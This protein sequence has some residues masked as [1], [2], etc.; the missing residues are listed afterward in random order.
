MHRNF[1]AAVRALWVMAMIVLVMAS[2][3]PIKKQVYLQTE[4]SDTTKSE[5]ILDNTPSYTLQPGNNLYIKVFSVDDELYDFFNLGFG[6][7]GNI[8]YD[9]AVYLNSYSV[10]D[11]GKVELPFIGEIFV[12]DLTLEQ[13]KNKIQQ[14]IDKYL[15]NTMII[16]KLV[17]YTVTVVGEVQRP[18]QFKVYQDQIS[19]YE[20]LALAGDMTTFA[21]RDDVI[22]VRKTDKGSKIHHLN[23]L[24]DKF[25][26][27]PY[28]YI[29]PDDVVYVRPVKGKNFA[30]SSFPYTLV[31]SSISLAIALF[32]LFK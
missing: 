18:G 23:L 31:I 28:F 22:L 25:L 3:V 27:S 14:R 16:V 6:T 1:R 24:E 7:A 12:K 30:F 29:M 17:N 13:A 15:K 26:E 11:S 8:Y 19:I 10:N 4:E 2:C 9:A 21:K 5:Y 32:A 20:V